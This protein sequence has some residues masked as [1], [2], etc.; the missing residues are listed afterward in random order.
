MT[1][2][3]STLE[4][5]VK[6]LAG[7]KKT[8]LTPAKKS[9]PTKI[10]VR[11]N[12]NPEGNFPNPRKQVQRSLPKPRGTQRIPNPQFQL[13]KKGPKNPRGDYFLAPKGTQRPKSPNEKTC[14]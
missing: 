1:A 8:W 9:V 10:C 6:T 3:L 12:P 11:Y 13:W 2:G 5:A 4:W 7:S 14:Q